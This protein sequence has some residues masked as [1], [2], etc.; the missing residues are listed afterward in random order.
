MEVYILSERASNL[1]VCRIHTWPFL[2]LVTRCIN[3][4]SDTIIFQVVMKISISDMSVMGWVVAVRARET[5][6]KPTK[7]TDYTLLR[8]AITKE[9]CTW[10]SGAASANCLYFEII[11]CELEAPSS[12]YFTLHKCYNH[13]DLSVQSQG[14]AQIARCRGKLL[15]D[16]SRYYIMS[17]TVFFTRLTLCHASSSASG[18]SAPL[19]LY[20]IGDNGQFP[21]Q[22]VIYPSVNT[23]GGITTINGYKLDSLCP[24]LSSDPTAK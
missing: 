11:L 5:Y 12:R 22:S 7:T 13:C 2:S 20:D 15:K 1:Q 19:E 17:F 14:Y 6:R 10:S 16:K 24:G 8:Q 21:F 9:N 3:T 23:V 4:L 18:Q